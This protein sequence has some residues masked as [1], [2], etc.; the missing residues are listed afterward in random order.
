MARPRSQQVSLDTTAYYHCIGRCVRRAFLCGEDALTG[1]SFEH[2]RAWMVERLAT[3]KARHPVVNLL[4]DSQ[5]SPI[6][7][8]RTGDKQ[9]QPPISVQ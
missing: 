8:S 7:I 9:G 6:T 4:H 1:R 5:L 3:Q 2:R